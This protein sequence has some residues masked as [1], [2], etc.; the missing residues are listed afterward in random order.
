MVVPEPVDTPAKPTRKP[1]ATTPRQPAAPKPKAPDGVAQKLVE[2][3]V[4]R[5]SEALAARPTWADLHQL[6]GRLS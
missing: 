2:R 1:R 4:A 5:L 6:E 3:E